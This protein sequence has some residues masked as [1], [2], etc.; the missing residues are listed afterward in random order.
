MQAA[1]SSDDDQ[2]EAV[3]VARRPVQ[4]LATRLSAPAASDSSQSHGDESDCSDYSEQDGGHAQLSLPL[5][6]RAMAQQRAGFRRQALKS[7]SKEADS[8]DDLPKKRLNKHAP[9]EERIAR[10]PVSV[11]RDSVQRKKL[12]PKD[13]RFLPYLR[14]DDPKEMEFA[15]RCSPLP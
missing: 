12:K 9:V 3:P 2:A 8:G 13:P 4:E 15:N 7:T 14:T 11:L 1:D 6:E 10:K 5:G